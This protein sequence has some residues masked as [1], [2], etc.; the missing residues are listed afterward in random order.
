MRKRGMKFDSGK[1]RFDWIPH[2]ALRQIAAA[3]T[4][5]GEKYA[6]FNWQGLTEEQA[7]ASAM[8]HVEA[9]RAGELVDRE[10]GVA[11]LGCAATQLCFV[12]WYRREQ[13]PREWDFRAVAKKFSKLKK[14]SQK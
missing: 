7:I 2:E 6:P 3:F 10:S 9:H 11:H 8:R 4:Y 12:L 13:L 1:I 14:K 5:G